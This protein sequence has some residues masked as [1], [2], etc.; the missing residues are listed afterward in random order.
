MKK[1]EETAN[2][3]KGEQRE[4][5]CKISICVR[6]VGT[7]RLDFALCDFIQFFFFIS[8][9]S[10]FF[11]SLCLS[12][13]DEIKTGNSKVCSF[14]WLTHSLSCSLHIRF[15]FLSVQRTYSFHLFA[16]VNTLRSNRNTC[17]R[18]V[19]RTLQKLPSKSIG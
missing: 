18:E 12:D 5:F 1:Q 13:D 2:E 16:K 14:C 11:P 9:F 15:Q 7:F 17:E 3:R 19:D 10:L 6:Y 4:K 8:G